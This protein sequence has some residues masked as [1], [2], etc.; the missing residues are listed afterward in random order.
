MSPRRFA[1]THSGECSRGCFRRTAA[2]AECCN[3]EWRLAS[4]HMQTLH[5]ND[6]CC[7]CQAKMCRAWR[8]THTHTSESERKQML[9]MTRG[10]LALRR[11]CARALMLAAARHPSQRVGPRRRACAEPCPSRGCRGVRPLQTAGIEGATANARVLR[12]R[13]NR[14]GPALR[15]TDQAR[16]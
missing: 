13:V 16:A 5:A 14:S 9:L 8:H 4:V 15:R 7:T 6:T 12:D 2:K 3:A 1:T 10:R 11:R